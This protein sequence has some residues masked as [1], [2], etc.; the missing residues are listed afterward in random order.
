MKKPPEKLLQLSALV[1]ITSVTHEHVSTGADTGYSRVVLIG[2]QGRELRAKWLEVKEFL[3]FDPGHHNSVL[4]IKDEHKQHVRDWSNFQ[5]KHQ[6][7]KA[8]YLRLK[9]I[10]EGEDE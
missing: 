8:E 3:D 7:E 9:K 5:R 10:F 2:Y 4:Q 1:C 6:E